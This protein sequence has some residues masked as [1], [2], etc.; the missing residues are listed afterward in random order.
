MNAKVLIVAIVALGVI[1]FGW[2]AY[3]GFSGPPV[4]TIVNDSTVLLSDIRIRGDGWSHDFPGVD[5]GAIVDAI[6]TP[7]GE[8]GVEITFIAGGERIARDDLAYIEREGGYCVTITVSEG[9]EIS[10]QTEIH[11]FSWRRAV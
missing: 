3:R 5:P 10:V 4:I 2:V 11:C 9:M 1:A 6:A 8:S 7:R